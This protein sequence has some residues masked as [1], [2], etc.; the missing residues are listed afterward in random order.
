MKPSEMPRDVLGLAQFYTRPMMANVVSPAMLNAA[1]TVQQK[2]SRD[3]AN[4]DQSEFP[5]YFEEIKEAAQ[6]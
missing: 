4:L 3:I 6:D 2:G 5:D 1:L